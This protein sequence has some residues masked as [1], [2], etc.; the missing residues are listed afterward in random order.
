MRIEHTFKSAYRTCMQVSEL[1]FARNNVFQSYFINELF[2][3]S[4]IRMNTCVPFSL[5]FA[6]GQYDHICNLYVLWELQ[7]MLDILGNVLGMQ[8]IGVPVDFISLLFGV[9]GN[10][11]KLSG[12]NA[13]AHTGNADV[14]A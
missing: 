5:L 8:D 11:G 1:L 3:S 9:P 10:S 14:G 4:M 2:Y 6:G 7:N 12:D 13:R